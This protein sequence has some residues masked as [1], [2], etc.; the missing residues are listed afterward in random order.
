MVHCTGVRRVVYGFLFSVP[1]WHGERG[2]RDVEAL[3]QVECGV[4][5]SLPGGGRPQVERIAPPTTL[6]ALEDVVRLVDGEAAAG[7]R[8][9]AVQRTRT[10]VRS[11]L[12]APR[13]VAEQLQHGRDRDGDADRREIQRGPSRLDVLL[14]RL[15]L[16]VLSLAD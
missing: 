1:G 16:V 3:A 6:E 9:G 7:A 10:A 4:V 2:R 8:A 11:A 13:L 12:T 5:R 14:V 15:R